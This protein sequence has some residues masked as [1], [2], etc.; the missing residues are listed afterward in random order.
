MADIRRRAKAS[1]GSIYHQFESK[2]HLA[3][4]VYLEGIGD[5]QAGL[6]AALEGEADARRG[7]RAMIAHHLGWVRANDDWARFL[8]QGR[9]SALTAEAQQALEELNSELMRRAG[10][11][12]DAQVEAGRLRRLPADIYVA[13]VAGPYLAP[14]RRDLSGPARTGVNEGHLGME[15]SDEECS[16]RLRHGLGLDG[17]D[18]RDHPRRAAGRVRHR[19]RAGRRGHDALRV[20]RGGPRE[21]DALRRVHVADEEVHRAQR[22]GAGPQEGRVLLQ[23]ALRRADRRGEVAGAPAVCRSRPRAEHHTQ[24]EGHRHGPD[25]LA[26]VL[27]PPAEEAYARDRA[28]VDGLS[29][30]AAGPARR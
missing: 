21:P 20:R 18:G 30:G 25:P 26:R 9:H 3:A 7:I 1:T 8:F 17:R 2:E 28:G 6:I 10:R 22:R 14:T 13:L 29:Q 16:H 23:R 4:E 11:W 5:H 24:E 19:G 27:R 15:G 12:F